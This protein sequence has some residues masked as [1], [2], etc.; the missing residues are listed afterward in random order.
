MDKAYLI[1]RCFVSIVAAAVDMEQYPGHACDS[2]IAR[3]LSYFPNRAAYSTH[4]EFSQK[5]FAGKS[6]DVW[7]R[8][9]LG[10]GTPPQSLSLKNAIDIA[11][12]LHISFIELYIQA[13]ALVDIG[14]SLDRDCAS[15]GNKAGKGR[16]KSKSTIEKEKN[17]PP[18]QPDGMPNENSTVV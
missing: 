15:A 9:R 3:A 17:A 1:E 12:A 16:R 4:T 14:W 7:K 8:I 6:A 10:S 5:A 13:K 2:D 11:D 18:A